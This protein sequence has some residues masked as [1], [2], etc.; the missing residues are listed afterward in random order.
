MTQRQNEP[1]LEDILSLSKLGTLNSGFKDFK[2]AL[3]S[4]DMQT[5]EATSRGVS[6]T[7]S[8][9]TNP[10]LL[11]NATPQAWSE[12][13]GHY[14][15]THEE[16]YK[17]AFEGAKDG[18]LGFYADYIEAMKSA[19][20][21]K[22][23]ADTKI[24][25]KDKEEAIRL[26]FLSQ[27][28]ALL[29]RMD[30]NPDYDKFMS[31]KPWVTSFFIA[32]PLLII[33]LIPFLLQID[34]LTSLL[35]IQS[36][37]TFS[38]LG[39]S[40]LG[41]G[42]LFDFQVIDGKTVGPFGALGVILSLFI[43][44]SFALFFSVSYKL[45]TKEL[46]KA[47]EKTKILEDEFTNSL[48]QL[49]NRLADGVPAEIAFAKVAQSTQGQRTSSFFSLVSQNIQQ[50][51]MSVERAIFD[52]RRGAIIYYPSS[53]IATSMK[54]LVESVK[55]G[56]QVAARSLM[57]ISEYV[58]NIQ[59]I[60]Q[61]LKDL[62]AE[63]VSDMKSNM[64]FLAPLLAGIVVGLSAMITIILSK[65]QAIQDLTEAGSAT[66]GLGL[67]KIITIF[68]VTKMIPPYFMQLTIGIYIIEIVFILTIALVTV[69]SGKDTL[70][71]KYDISRFLRTAIFLY[72]ATALLSTIA[73]TILASVALG[74]LTG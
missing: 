29:S 35:N 16:E 41:E 25:K 27:V 74:G 47:R 36:D 67:D 63:V 62:L 28:G 56:L 18:L 66:S 51:G 11:L 72:L 38:Q 37:Y 2:R 68:D 15:S 20:T 40:L 31:K 71:E 55:K 3:K 65:L 23:N 53:L 49:G 48:F 17:K 10:D 9:G 14:K 7:M 33:G 58:K 50:M 52:T 13:V 44:L 26:T 24:K 19:I 4:N 22:V 42:K 5:M 73:L 43:P 61:R 54:I 60:N 64:T 30:L 39:I 57:S 34:S 8:D 46:I 32:L 12:S 1:K 69:D 70:K 6:L 59:K 45:K 21:E